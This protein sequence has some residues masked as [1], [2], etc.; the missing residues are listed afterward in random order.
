MAPD[1]V[2]TWDVPATGHTDGVRTDRAGWERRV[3]GFLD[4]QL[5]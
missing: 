4:A 3:V 2:T 1:R 5:R